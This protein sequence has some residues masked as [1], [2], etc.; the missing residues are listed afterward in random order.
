ML[1]DFDP[2]VPDPHTAELLKVL[3]GSIGLVRIG[4]GLYEGS[5]NAH[6]LFE[7]AICND[8]PFGLQL[9]REANDE[10]LREL[11]QAYVENVEKRGWPPDSYGVSDSLEQVI[12]RYPV[13]DEDPRPLAIIGSVIR[14][15]EQPWSGGWR[16][17]KWGE[18]IGEH[19]PQCEYLY[20]EIGI[21]QVWVWHVYEINPESVITVAEDG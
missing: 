8:Y 13:I 17:H 19:E 16:W 6:H 20:D 4:R 9:P 1:V 3:E 7:T 10:K 2:G 15:D 18:Y 21:D 11:L 14:W 5:V 12:E